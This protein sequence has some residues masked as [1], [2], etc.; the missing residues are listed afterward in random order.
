MDGW[1]YFSK[2]LYFFLIEEYNDKCPYDHIPLRTSPRKKR[3]KG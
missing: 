2:Y 1:G 3:N